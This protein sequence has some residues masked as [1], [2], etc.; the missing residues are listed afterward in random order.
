MLTAFLDYGCIKEYVCMLFL[1]SYERMHFH[2]ELLYI[3]HYKKWECTYLRIYELTSQNHVLFTQL[4][5]YT[6]KQ[7]TIELYIVESDKYSGSL[8]RLDC[9]F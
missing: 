3:I 9:I 1:F 5:Q 6:V 7:Y 4:K 2:F 8:K